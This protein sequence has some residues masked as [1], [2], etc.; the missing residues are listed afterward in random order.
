MVL[1]EMLDVHVCRLKRPLGSERSPRVALNLIT[2]FP[3][4]VLNPISLLWMETESLRRC[5]FLLIRVA[6]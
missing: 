3:A 5:V 1:E 2:L 6:W 4:S